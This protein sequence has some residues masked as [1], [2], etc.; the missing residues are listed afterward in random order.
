MTEIKPSSRVVLND[1]KGLLKGPV[2]GRED[3][4]R[5]E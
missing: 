1:I 4:R 5:V 2:V 3:F